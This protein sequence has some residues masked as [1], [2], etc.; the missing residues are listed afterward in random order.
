M[1]LTARSSGV[2]LIERT[3]RV[4]HELC[5]PPSCAIDASTSPFIDESYSTTSSRTIAKA[6]V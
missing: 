2:V 4:F 3:G 1:A 6:W 5:G